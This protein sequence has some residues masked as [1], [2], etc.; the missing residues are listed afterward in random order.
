MN[1][2]RMIIGV[3][4]SIVFILVITAGIN[5]ITC[6]SFDYDYIYNGYSEEFVTDDSRYVYTKN[7]EPKIINKKS[8]EGYAFNLD[9]FSDESKTPMYSDGKNI[10]FMI[11]DGVSE[12]KI[13][14]YDKNFNIHYLIGKKENNQLL[15]NSGLGDIFYSDTYLEIHEDYLNTPTQFI[16]VGRNVFLYCPGGIYKYNLFSHIKTKIF[17]EK[18]GE[19]S[20]SYANGFIYFQ[21]DLYNF[22]AYDIKNDVLM[23]DFN[24]NPY[25]FCVNNKG[26]VYSD[27]NNQMYLTF[28]DFNTKENSVICNKEIPAFDLDDKA[29]YYAIKGK[30]YKS[31]FTGERQFLL[32]K[33]KLCSYL[34]KGVDELY[35]AYDF[36]DNVKIEKLDFD[37]I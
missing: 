19:T 13:C 8:G 16:V 27:L 34:N 36:C 35:I 30:Y 26:I 11:D 24:I 4:S 6:K 14:Y 23:D 21:D 5:L 37:E 10:F 20:F 33:N 15:A 29:I 9:L 32:G 31:D 25:C 22:Y 28:Y 17:D 18:T 7:L 1:K 3:C 2:K 12:Y